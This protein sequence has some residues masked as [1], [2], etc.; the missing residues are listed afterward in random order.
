V[1]SRGGA[2]I[3]LQTVEAE[4]MNAPV[5]SHLIITEAEYTSLAERGVIG[6]ALLL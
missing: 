6:E 2:P 4:V 3:I 5:H 1:D